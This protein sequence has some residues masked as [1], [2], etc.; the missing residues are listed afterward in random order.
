MKTVFT[1]ALHSSVDVITNSSSEIFICS[2]NNSLED[3]KEILQSLLDIHHKADPYYGNNFDDVFGEI[4]VLDESNVDSYIDLMVEW[5]CWPRD[6]SYHDKQYQKKLAEARRL[7]RKEHYGDPTE[8]YGKIV[9]NSNGDNSI[10]WGIQQSIEELF[11][12]KRTHLG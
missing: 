1:I 7:Y 5:E 12:A 3:V 9:I 10:P 8:L 6:I 4:Y 11:H 2:T